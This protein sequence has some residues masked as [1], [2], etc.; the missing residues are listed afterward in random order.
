M[1]VPISW[2]KTFVD[3]DLPVEELAERLNLAGIEVEVIEGSGEDQVLVLS[4]LANTARAQSI[5][6]V[7]RE[8]AALTGSALHEDL[9]LADLPAQTDS[10][11]PTA[12]V[13]PELCR[14]FSVAEV[15][16]VK[17]TTSPSWLQRRLVLAGVDPINNIVDAANYVMFELGQPMHTYDAALL[18]DMRLGVRMARV[19]ET[20]HTI[21]Q[22]DDDDPIALP[23]GV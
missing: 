19:L 11:R 8:V 9:D 4:I 15:A 14:R 10:L 18:P 22:P 3:I 17:V 6:G 1:R 2:L 13:A 7:A 23:D 12:D 5:A 16:N 20:L 21:A